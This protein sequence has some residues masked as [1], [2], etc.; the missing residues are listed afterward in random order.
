MNKNNS[1]INFKLYFI[2]TKKFSKV[3]TLLKSPMAQKKFSKEQVGVSYYNV[4]F[5][6]I[7]NSNYL[8]K[9]GINICDVNSIFII[10]SLLKKEIFNIFCGLFL[11]H[12]FNIVFFIKYFF[13]PS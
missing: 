9:S 3:F 8:S 11:F 10:V 7:L 1:L 13:K 5:N 2:L 4:T 12:G 6:I